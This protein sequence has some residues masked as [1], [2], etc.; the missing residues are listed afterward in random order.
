MI[1]NLLQAH[2]KLPQKSNWKTAEATANLIGN[3]IADKIKNISWT[4]PE[5]N[6]ETVTNKRENTGRDREI[7]RE[8]YVPLGKR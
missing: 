2:L 3:K 5:N 4:S 1:N 6:S 8:R 7:P